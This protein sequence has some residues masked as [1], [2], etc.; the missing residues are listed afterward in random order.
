MA[1]APSAYLDNNATTPL[2][3]E[4]REAMLP[5]L[6]DGFGNPSSLHAAGLRAKAALA[7]ARAR[8]AALVGAQPS[9]VV[10]TSGGTEADSLAILGALEAAGER[11]RVVTTAVEH[12][13]VRDLLRA[14]RERGRVELREIGVAP[15]GTLDAERVA[16]AVDGETALVSVMWANNETGLLHPVEAIARACRE[17]GVPLHLDAVQAAG[18]VPVDLGRVPAD[19]L[20]I[21]AHKIHGPPGVGALVVRRGARWKPGLAGGRQEGG[22]RGG[23][24]NLPGIAGFGAAAEAARRELPAEPRVRALRDRFESIVLDGVPGARRSSAAEP[25]TPNTSNLLLPGAEGESIVLR[26]DARGIAV[27]TGSACTAGSTE[28]SH[29]LVAMGI[30]ARDARGAIRVSLSR[31]TTEEEVERAARAVVEEST[32]T[33]RSRS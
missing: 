25:R 32:P 10:F 11:R 12:P 30:P 15:D 27:S 21:S 24:E 20:S 9:E 2:C 17:K 6:G 33:R 13:A 8:V 28:P 1:S 23:T 3:P 4:A 18:K 26:L 5:L 7:Q 29:V 31:Y 22:R 14:L 16:A 19:L